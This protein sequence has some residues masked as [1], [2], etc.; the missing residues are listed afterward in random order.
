MGAITPLINSR[1]HTSGV[2][3]DIYFV[4]FCMCQYIARMPVTT[5]T[6]TFLVYID[7]Q[8]L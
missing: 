4:L 5:R 1:A 2:F 6:P 7:P 8:I 3:L